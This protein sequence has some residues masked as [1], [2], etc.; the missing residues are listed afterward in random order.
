MPTGIYTRSQAIK[1]NMKIKMLGNTSHLGFKNSDE[2]KLKMSLSGKGKHDNEKNP[3]WKEEGYTYT[4]LHQW[5]KRK[6]G[7]PAYCS[8]NSEHKAKRFVWAN[9]S[10]EY[11][12]DLTDFRQLC[13]SCNR[14]DG[15]KIHERF[16]FQRV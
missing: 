12:R 7:S 10:G 2:S 13:T 9:I 8:N 11:R 6:L 15:I 16:K 4:A 1:D 3:S 14:T 5:I